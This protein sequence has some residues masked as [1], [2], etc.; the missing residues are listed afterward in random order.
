MGTAMDGHAS[1]LA[2]LY[3]RIN[4]SSAERPGSVMANADVAGRDCG[5][6]QDSQAVLRGR[7]V[8]ETRF[9]LLSTF[10]GRISGLPVIHRL[11]GWDISAAGEV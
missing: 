8:V 5:F 7:A 4:Q 2:S 1:I 3:T 11:I 6:T 9:G 10:D